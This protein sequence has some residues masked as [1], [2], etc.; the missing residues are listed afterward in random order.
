MTLDQIKG[1]WIQLGLNLDDLVFNRYKINNNDDGY[2]VGYYAVLDDDYDFYGQMSIFPEITEGWYKFIPDQSECGGY[3]YLDEEKKAEIIAEREA[4]EKRP[5][6]MDVLE[7]Q[8]MWTAL[9][10]DTML[11]EEE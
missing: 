11:P 4:A 1:I 10:T 8:M 5:T 7:A 3:F 2:V 9:L 6:E